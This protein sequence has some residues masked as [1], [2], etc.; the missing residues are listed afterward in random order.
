MLTF[1]LDENGEQ[2]HVC[3]NPEGLEALIEH[4][5]RLLDSAK[6]GKTEHIHLM[7]KEWGDGDLTSEPQIGK[8]LN[9][10]KVLCWPDEEP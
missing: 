6:R 7:T 8:L 5:S 9:H 2:L 4:L 1:E 10:V 3:T